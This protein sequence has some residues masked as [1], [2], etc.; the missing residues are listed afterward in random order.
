MVA[1]YQPHP[2][3]E[4]WQRLRTLV[5]VTLAFTVGLAAGSMFGADCEVGFLY[6]PFQYWRLLNLISQSP[7]SLTAP[8]LKEAIMAAR[9]ELGGLA[10]MGASAAAAYWVGGPM[11]VQAALAYVGAAGGTPVG[12]HVAQ[13]AQQVS[14]VHEEESEDPRTRPRQRRPRM[15]ADAECLQC[16]CTGDHGAECGQLL[17]T[18]CG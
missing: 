9:G 6:N 13:L 14:F 17:G 15:E 2:G 5:G 16:R 1:G 11:A 10:L 3:I 8:E 12:A 18:G 7:W 4:A